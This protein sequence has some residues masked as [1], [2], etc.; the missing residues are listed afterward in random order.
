MNNVSLVKVTLGVA[1]A[2]VATFIV[3]ANEISPVAIDVKN[4]VAAEAAVSMQSP[5]FT[6]LLSTF[7]TD[8]NGA[9]SESELSSSALQSDF[10]SIDT[11]GD[12]NINEDEFNAYV[13][14]K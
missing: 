14:S 9:L 2:A 7:D 11:D 6:E 12:T 4:E 13:A 5:S 1:F 8:E 3:N 10:S